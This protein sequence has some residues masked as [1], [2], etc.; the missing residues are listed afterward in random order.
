MDCGEG[1]VEMKGRRLLGK[2][3]AVAQTGDDGAVHKVLAWG[4][5]KRPDTEYVWEVEK[6][7]LADGLNRSNERKTEG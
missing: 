3:F 4:W 2:V 5:K 6:T 7:G 1:M